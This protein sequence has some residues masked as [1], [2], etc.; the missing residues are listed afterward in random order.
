MQKYLKYNTFACL[1]I[2]D[3]CDKNLLYTKSLMLTVN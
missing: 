3:G 1:I 2:S